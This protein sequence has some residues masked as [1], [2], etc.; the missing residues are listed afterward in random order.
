M[1]NG[2][3]HTRNIAQIIGSHTRILTIY[4]QKKYPGTVTR[5]YE[6]FMRTYGHAVKPRLHE[7][8]EARNDDDQ[9]IKVNIKAERQTTTD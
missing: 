1:T 6:I 8:K 3:T 9:S 2:C 5:R 4:K 7:R